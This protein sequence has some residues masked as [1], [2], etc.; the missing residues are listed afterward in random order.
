MMAFPK[1]QSAD[2]LLK[3]SIRFDGKQEAIRTLARFSLATC[4][5][6]R[7]SGMKV[8]VAPQVKFRV[9]LFKMKI[10]GL[11]LTGCAWQ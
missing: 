11:A 1:H 7:S 5:E 6:I 4:S 8:W 2:E 3:P 9:L 10:Q